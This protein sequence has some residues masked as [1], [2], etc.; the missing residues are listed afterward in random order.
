MKDKKRSFLSDV[1]DWLETVV[2]AVSAV[3]VLFSFVLRVVDVDG[4]SMTNTLLNADKLLI[5]N[6]FY[7]PEVGDIVVISRADSYDKEQTSEPLIKRVIATEGQLVDIDF[8]TG[9]V[10]VDG[11][12]LKEDYIKE[13]TYL[14]A[15]V[16]FPVLVTDNCVF[17]MG[18]NRNDSKDSRFSEIG[19][20][21]TDRIIGKALV[22][23]YP[24]SD[25]EFFI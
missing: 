13:P 14:K 15:D 6:V 10:Y 8:Q 17:V 25:I 11:V 3:A 19:M 9:S 23:V 1:Y 2:I 7:E 22:R 20:V 21:P 16:D 4:D 5:S 18:D 24:F 12:L